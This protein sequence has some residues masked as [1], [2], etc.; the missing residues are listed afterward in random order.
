M[1]WITNSVLPKI[2][3]WVKSDS[4]SKN[5]WIKCPSCEQMLFE[6][7]FKETFYCCTTCEHHSFMPPIER[8]NFYYG[9]D[10]F[11]ILKT[12]PQIDDPLKFKDSKKY[13]DRLKAARLKTKNDDAILI[14]YG[15]I[16][17]MKLIS[18]ALNFQ[19]MGG[20]M[21]RA[22]GDGIILAAE[23]AIKRNASLLVIPSS[24]GARMQEGIF[25][26]M[27]LPRTIIAIEKIKTAKLPY[28]VLLTNPTMGGVT[29]SFSMLGDIHIAEP[30]ALIG[31]AGRRV[32]EETVREKLPENFQ[33]AEYLRDHGMVDMVVPRSEQRETIINILSILTKN[34]EK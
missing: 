8:F 33:K 7:D 1:N 9:I 12:K 16:G 6:K 34:I 13:P 10:N 24:G 27:Q 30:N 18:V 14:A 23:E 17:N 15:K 29:A 31:F 28:I 11:E 32:I 3:A 22:V 21:G 26:L 5:L 4:S 20:S 19:F 2:K 25:S